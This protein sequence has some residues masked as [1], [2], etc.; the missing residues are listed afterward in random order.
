MHLK[1]FKNNLLK[2][3][4]CDTYKDPFWAH[5]NKFK[6]VLKLSKQ[7]V[8]VPLNLVHSRRQNIKKRK[9][10]ICACAEHRRHIEPE[11]SQNNF[12]LWDV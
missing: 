4:K 3:K 2:N 9:V 8:I 7:M 11:G 1:C 10:N 6:N 12:D 5:L